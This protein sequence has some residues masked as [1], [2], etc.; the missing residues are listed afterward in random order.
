MLQYIQYKIFICLKNELFYT[1]RQLTAVQTGGDNMSG[2][3][4]STNNRTDSLTGLKSYSAFRQEVQAVID[5]D[6]HGIVNGGY[7]LIYFDIM[8]FKVIN[9]LFGTQEGDNFLVFMAQQITAI[10]GEGCIATRI[11]SDRF[12]LFA[13]K[14]REE[15]DRDVQTFLQNVAEYPLPYEIICNMGIYVTKRIMK[16]EFMLDRAILAYSI[17]K[18]DYV[19]RYNYYDSSQRDAM[20]GEQEITSMMRA[21]LADRQFVV[22]YQ[23][24]YNHT[25][26][27]LVGAE[28]L[29]RWKHP[30]RGIIPPGVFIPI[31]EKNGFITELDLYVFDEVCA[32]I[33]RSI[34]H[35]NK[36]VPISVNISRRDIYKPDIVGVMESIR[37]KY[38][39]PVELLRI[40]VTESAI[41]DGVQQLNDVIDQL[42]KKNYIIEMDDFGSAYSSLNALK[43]IDL[44]ILKLDLKFLSDDKK[45][46]DKK[47]GGIILSHVVRM[48]K[49][50]GFSVIAEGVEH[51][52]Q[53]DYLLSIGCCNIQGFLYARPMPESDYTDLLKTAQLSK[54]MPA[55][56]LISTMDADNFWDPKSLETLIFNN[57]VGG[58]VIFEYRS[59]DIEPLRI[60]KKY[61]REIGSQFTED[62]I[63]ASEPLGM[64][65]DLNKK[66]Y[67]DMLERAIKSE[68]EEECETWRTYE[69]GEEPICVRS[70]VQLIGKSVD[71]YLFYA[72]IRNITAEKKAME[73]IIHREKLFR[74]ASEQVNI[75]YWEYDVKSKNMYPCFRCIRDLHLPDVV[76]NYPEP[77]IEMGIFPTEVADEYREI[78][79]R[80]ENG[81]KEIETVMPLT[82]ARVPFKVR[83]TTEFDEN[84]VPVRAYGSAAMV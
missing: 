36:T 75:Y 43:N 16:A 77:A 26:G 35:G 37:Q 82:A 11:N 65:D 72:M 19:K 52:E 25:D 79:R 81:E 55:M 70:S 60:N 58:A 54:T 76:C 73:E 50:L 80:I 18:G 61:I 40:E 1:Q 3:N 5:S 48:A 15:T 9:D 53:A 22:Y 4:I 69:G 28:A 84:G 78:H 46:S 7:V 62:H 23:P 39:V 30:K 29:V 56:H 42:H 6:E 51:M 68:Q 71:S 17:I 20:L 45:E 14:G 24:Q 34:D 2:N 38:D 57:Y 32:F 27:S 13:K 21:A 8:R 41:I 33:R 64:L 49:W 12:A 83:Y 67:L 47:H 74:A 59:G 44:D 63:M 66:I 31:F 10:G